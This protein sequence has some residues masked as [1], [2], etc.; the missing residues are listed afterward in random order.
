M[1]R[2]TFKDTDIMWDMLAHVRLLVG[3]VGIREEWAA[4]EICAV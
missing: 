4:H 2:L 3:E 1:L